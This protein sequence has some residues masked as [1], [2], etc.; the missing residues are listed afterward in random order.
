MAHEAVAIDGDEVQR[1]SAVLGRCVDATVVDKVGEALNAQ[2]FRIL[3]DIA[4]DLAGDMV[5]PTCFDTALH[6]RAELQNPDVSVARIAK[7]VG[8]EPL[9]AA[10]LLHIANSAFFN[11]SGIP[12]CT[13]PDAIVRLG[14]NL[15][16]TTALAVAMNQ[17]L[18]SREMVV[19]EELTNMLW[20]HSIRTAVAA[21][22]LAHSQ[23][24]LNPDE[25]LLAGLV[26]DLGAFYMLYRATQYP[27]VRA[28]PESMKYLIAQWHES[29][30]VALLN[31]LGL[32]E[33]IVAATEDHDRP[34]PIPKVVH[35]LSETVYVG[36]LLAG[37]NFEWMYQELAPNQED[38]EAVRSNFAAL[39]PDIEQEAQEMLAVFA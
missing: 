13:L 34:R 17:L 24:R 18:R 23:T 11:P 22:V 12:V 1:L 37:A 6:L 30:G 28:R 31:A 21:R 8:L 33:E 4:R 3:T 9:V 5:F 32:P 16:R 39:L 19:F 2:R 14:V 27:E 35:T 7:V 38:I 15:V 10:K 26:H 25:A 29:V 36:N 20:E